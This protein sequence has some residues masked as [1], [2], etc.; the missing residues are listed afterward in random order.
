[1]NAWTFDDAGVYRLTPELA[2]VQT[3]DFFTPIVDDPKSFGRIAIANALSDVYAMGGRP[4]NALNILCYPMEALGHE[5]LHE[6]LAGA[7]EKYVEAKCA[8]LGGH[9]VTDTELKFGAAVTGLVHPDRIWTNAGAKVGDALVLS[10]RLGTGILTTAMKARKFPEADAAAVVA[11]MEQ[12]NA[13]GVVAA[14][15]K[16][17]HAA[18]DITGYALAGHGAGMAEASGVTL[19]IRASQVPIFPEAEKF[20]AK[21]QKTRGDVSNREWLGPKYRTAPGVRKPLEDILFDPQTSGGLLF[22][23]PAAQ[24]DRLVADLKKNGFGASAVIGEVREKSVRLVE[25]LD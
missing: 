7:N 13:G 11:Q 10:K 18:T 23:L 3:V 2:L 17:V 4:I 15:G 1:V 20:A 22:S 25:F 5:V 24:A 14:E 16:D 12:L 8:L 21:G 19:V 9:S 6:I